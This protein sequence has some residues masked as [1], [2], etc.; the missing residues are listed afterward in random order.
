LGGLLLL[1]DRLEEVVDAA[2]EIDPGAGHE[3][4][5]LAAGV[6]EGVVLAGVSGIG[7]DP[8]GGEEGFGLEA[9][10]DGVDG[11]LGQHELGVLLEETDDF[12]T[13]EATVPEGGERGHLER[14][15]AELGLPGS[16]A[17]GP[18]A[19]GESFFGGLVKVELITCHALYLA[20]LC[21]VLGI[22][23]V[24]RIVWVA[25]LCGWLAR[26]RADLR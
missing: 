23:F 3:T 25:E 19:D 24:K 20:L 1:E 22:D 8:L 11:A 10:E 17:A 2:G 12:E 18:F 14:A 9:V 13:I 4:E 15:L 21:I 6:G 26:S 5:A 7:L 16:C